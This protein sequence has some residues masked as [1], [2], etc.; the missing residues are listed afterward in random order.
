MSHGIDV[1]VAAVIERD[2]RFLFVEER[3]GGKLVLN[4]PAGHV[5]LGESVVDAVIRETREETGHV[6]EPQH[7]VGIYLWQADDGPTFLRLTFCGTST[8]PSG[9]GAVQLDEGIVATHWLTRPQLLARENDHRSPMVLR[10]LD[11]YLAGVRRPLETITH[12]S[13]ALPPAALVRRAR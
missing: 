7:L 13:N 10:C 4:Q 11:D 2:D 9:S 8:P 6:F 1:T 5:E 12:L 3:V